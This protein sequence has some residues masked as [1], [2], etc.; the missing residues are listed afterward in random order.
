ML[1][2]AKREMAISAL[3]RVRQVGLN[4]AGTK[5]RYTVYCVTDLR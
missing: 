3:D 4:K 2:L 1:S 5:G